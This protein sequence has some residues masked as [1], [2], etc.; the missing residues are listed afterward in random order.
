[1]NIKKVEEIENLKTLI[2]YFRDLNR[3]RAVRVA[4]DVL[5]D[6]SYDIKQLIM[7]V[8]TDQNYF[9]E[10]GVTPALKLV[11]FNNRVDNLQTSVHALGLVRQL[12]DFL[13]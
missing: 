4:L 1:V 2:E 8:I 12:T 7:N 5:N 10:Q 9:L 13:I 11:P 3:N 6:L